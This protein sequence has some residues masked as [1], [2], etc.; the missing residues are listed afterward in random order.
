ML[1][2]AN[3]SA[4]QAEN[5][6]E[7][8]DY[9][10]R[11]LDDVDTGTPS[12]TWYGKGATALGLTDDFNQSTFQQLLHG[13]GPNGE[14]LHARKIDPDHHRAATD[15]T[16]SAPKSVS[17][18][19]LIQGD[20]R[21]LAAHDQAVRTAL[22]ILETRYAQTRIRRP[23]RERKR[24]TTG[25]V[26][27]AIFRHETSREQ[28]P[29]LHSHCVLINATQLDNS[30][31]R[32]LSNEAIVAHQK[33]LGEI[34][35][36]ELAYQLRHHGYDITPTA[37]GQFELTGYG[38]ELLNTFSTRTQQIETYLEKWEQKL[39]ET[40][41]APLHRSQQK[42]ATLD[43]RRRKTTVPRSLLLTGWAETIQ[44]QGLNLPEVPTQDIDLNQTSQTAAHAAATLGLDHAAERESV[45]KQ[46]KAERF[47]L[48]HGLGQQSF[49]DL[50]QALR[51]HPNRIV[52]DDQWLTTH[53]ALERER[54][55]IQMMVGGQGQV[56]P[57]ATP[58][59]VNQR[60]SDA[61]SLTPGQREAIWLSATT[62]D[63]IIAWQGVAGSGKTHSLNLY[64]RIAQDQ[65]HDVTG[66][67]PSAQAANVLHQDTGIPTNTVAHLLHTP[68][69]DPSQFKHSSTKFPI[70]IVDEAGLLSAKAAHTLLQKAEVHQ[71]RV[72]LVGDTRQLS[73]VEAGNPFKSLQEAG[74]QTAI[75]N[76]SRRQQTEALKTA[77]HHIAQGDIPTG[78]QQ[79]DEAGFIQTVPLADRVSALAQDYLS[80]TP[81]QRKKTL[82]LSGT[83]DD[84]LAIT[85]KL[86][87]ALQQ[88]GRLE[89]DLFT[90]QS[91]RPKDLTQ[92]QA[93]YVSHY[94]IGDVIVPVRNYPRHGLERH[95]RYTVTAI[96]PTHNHLILQAPDGQTLTFNPVHC[97]KKTSYRIQQ[98]P[99]AIGDQL[100]WTRNDRD[101]GIRNGQ[102]FTI[103]ALN[104]QGQAQILTADGT[105][106]S[107]NLRGHH[108]IDYGLVST[109]Y[110][111]QGK[112]AERVLVAADSTLT[113]EAF[114]VAVSRAKRHL[115]L[116]TPNKDDLLRIAQRSR[117]NQNASDYLSLYQVTHHG[118]TPQTPTSTP[119]R[120]DDGRRIGERLA[121]QLTTA[122]RRDSRAENPASCL[123]Q[124][125]DRLAASLDSGAATAS[126]TRQSSD[127][128][129]PEL[130]RQFAAALR[131][132]R[133][134]WLL[135]QQD[136]QWYEH[137]AAQQP[138]EQPYHQDQMIVHQYLQE[139]CGHQG[140]PTQ[141]QRRQA[142]RILFQ[143]PLARQLRQQEGRTAAVEYVKQQVNAVMQQRMHM[144][145]QQRYVGVD[146]ER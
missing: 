34:Y 114:Y 4:A 89:C 57:I 123:A 101:L 146:I 103:T 2:I 35:Q 62:C 41:G 27:A 65:G 69:P 16:F 5:Y 9:Y 128:T 93:R 54:E 66:Y 56:D 17:I 96:D 67:A 11:D 110:S 33:L 37:T 20:T 52:I 119:N 142:A 76:Q 100:R 99:I 138:P 75:L 144:R 1:S 141:A 88:E 92:A 74:I 10:T 40:G 121:R 30:Q 18:A 70:W 45:F 15:C 59:E 6:Y 82:I 117:A 51:H 23:Q 129:V 8:D 122:L 109:T 97:A 87:H 19:A 84:R 28:D 50:H 111:S 25:N 24:V 63:R 49:A 68:D 12:A 137:Y 83:N 120:R 21:V 39:T 94:A 134:Q 127:S 31:W 115:T 86:R 98:L 13:E 77:V 60:L 80:L 124:S 47:A 72:V 140:Q 112:T 36:N 132:R 73:A 90:L 61:L 7:A 32:S 135:T 116:Y 113:Q 145:Q 38:P 126:K 91:L 81:A 78:L 139:H 44:A 108:Y 85:Q 107:L 105:A 106:R 131:H 53:T 22:S 26:V 43:T 130:T 143:G 42:Q 102:Q 118:Q 104:D 29:Q 55:T 58:E 125:T 64:A 71:A 136:R 133:Q 46:A 95:Q 14:S 3:V 48:E 79:L